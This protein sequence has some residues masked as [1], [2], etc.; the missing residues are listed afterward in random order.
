LTLCDNTHNLL[1]GQRVAAPL[2]HRH[3][4]S[5]PVP[6]PSSPHTEDA[7]RPGA[8]RLDPE[9]VGR[10]R[11]LDPNGSQR[12]LERA[13]EAFETLVDR[14]LPRWDAALEGGDLATI[15]PLAHTLKSAAGT[16]GALALADDCAALES[17]LRHGRQDGV[18][19]RARRLRGDLPEVRAAVQAMAGTR[20]AAACLP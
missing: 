16:L 14:V 11:A 2:S 17:S 13:A 3:F 9:A 12:L 8:V 1:P 6:D 15:A 10:L 5:M 4:S 19:E 18:L 7:G 20:T